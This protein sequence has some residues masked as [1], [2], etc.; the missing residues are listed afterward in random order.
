MEH[1]EGECTRDSGNKNM[2]QK[3]WDQ[4]E[5]GPSFEAGRGEGR[6]AG[7]G[8]RHKEEGILGRENPCG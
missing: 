8:S 7:N 2:T 1:G 5:T 3:P 4:K 6:R